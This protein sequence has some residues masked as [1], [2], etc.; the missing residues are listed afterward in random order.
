MNAPPIDRRSDPPAADPGRRRRW[1]VVIPAMILPALGALMYFVWFNESH[2]IKILYA[3]TKLFTLVWPAV[4][5]LFVLRERWPRLGGWARHARALPLGMVTGGLIV[6][7]MF[8]LMTTPLGQVVADSAPNIRA[9]AGRFGILDYYWLFAALVSTLHALLEEYYWRW[10]V[11]GQL[12]RLVRPVWAHGWA[13]V[14]FAA[15]HVVITS[16]YFGLGWG[17]PLGAAVGLGGAI[18][19]WSYTRQGTLAGA[20]LSHILVD[21]GLFAVG[22]RILF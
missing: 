14:A 19:S 12:R 13:G 2:A 8:G 11:Y 7:A 22:S 16:V 6:L 4:A 15:H 9:K 20:W 5:V 3:G 21:L 17:V 18:W 10:F 1:L